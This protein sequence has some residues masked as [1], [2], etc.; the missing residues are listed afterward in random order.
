MLGQDTEAHMS[1]RKRKAEAEITGLERPI[2]DYLIK[3]LAARLETLPPR[4]AE[5]RRR[6]LCSWL[7][8]IADIR[9]NPH[10][11]PAGRDFYRILFDERFGGVEEL[12]VGRRFSRIARDGYAL[13]ESVDAAGIANRLRDFHAAFAAGCA[14]S[15]MSPD[16]VEALVAA[17][18]PGTQEPASGL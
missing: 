18:P 6:E 12:N 17:L 14:K 13:R 16:R 5:H 2:N 15:E 4:T 8:D 7:D 3:L 10:D 9:L 11:R 1:F